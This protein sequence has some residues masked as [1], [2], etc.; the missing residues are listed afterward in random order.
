M[1]EESTLD[2]SD[3]DMKPECDEKPFY[4]LPNCRIFLET[5]SPLYHEA[6]DFLVAIS[7]PVSRFVLTLFTPYSFF[8]P[9]YVH[10]YKMTKISLM[11]ALSIG[12]STQDIIDG[13]AHF[14]KVYFPCLLLLLLLLF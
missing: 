7:E 14:S 13:L 1:E 6:Y 9:P 3:L 2:F 5:F 4:V 11:S 8:S 12:L 10:E